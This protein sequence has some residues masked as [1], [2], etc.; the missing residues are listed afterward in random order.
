MGPFHMP[1]EFRGSRRQD[2]EGDV[3]LPA[4]LLKDGLKLA[5]SIY[6]HRLNGEGHPPHKAIQE[7][8]SYGGGGPGVYLQ[9]VPTTDYIAS[10]EML[11]HYP[12]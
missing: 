1:V 12:W 5:A 11:E 6:L 10:G 4:S 9:H 3:L 2:K 7:T 8:L